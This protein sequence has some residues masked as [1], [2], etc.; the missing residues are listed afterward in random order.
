M[1]IGK[2]MNI[3]IVFWYFLRRKKREKRLTKV[4]SGVII[5]SQQ[6]KGKHHTKAGALAKAKPKKKLCTA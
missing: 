2:W 6:R 5:M 3:G 4:F 1:K